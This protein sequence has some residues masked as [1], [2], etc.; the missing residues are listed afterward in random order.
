MPIVKPDPITFVLISCS[1][2][3]LATKAPARELYTGGLFQKAVA[4]AERHQH[5]WFIVSA[6]YG[7]VTPD[8]ELNPYDFT[9][10]QLR[11][12]EREA[13]GQR[14]ISALDKYTATGSHA[15]L[16]M[17]ELYRRNIQS[18]LLQYGITY[19]NPVKG[20]RIGQQ[21]RWLMSH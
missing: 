1:K 8:Q 2:S 16:I 13:W 7:L 21:K 5:P 3:K 4:W 12:R 17:P 18:A 20:M 9:L 15:F 6:L 10:K 11:A 14:T 19:E